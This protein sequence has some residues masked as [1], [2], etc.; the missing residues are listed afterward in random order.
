MQFKAQLEASPVKKKTFDWALKVGEEAIAYRMDDK[1]RYNM[2]YE[3]DLKSKLPLGLRMKYIV[4][5]K[6]FAKV[7]ALFGNRFRF[8]FSASTGIA[9]DLLKFFYI[10]GLPVMEGYGN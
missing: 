9:P 1:G 3:F 2:T 5:D 4:A 6:L 7:R 10:I 8:A